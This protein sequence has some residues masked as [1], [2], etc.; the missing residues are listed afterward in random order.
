MANPGDDLK[1]RRKRV[2]PVVP[3]L[4]WAGP[5]PENPLESYALAIVVRIAETGDANKGARNPDLP[6]CSLTTKTLYVVAC[7]FAYCRWRIREDGI[8]DYRTLLLAIRDT[9]ELDI[10]GWVDGHKDLVLEATNYLI[11]FVATERTPGFRVYG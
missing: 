8:K 2:V 3:H 5:E 11:E 9:K 1:P 4:S 6:P 7:M 10:K